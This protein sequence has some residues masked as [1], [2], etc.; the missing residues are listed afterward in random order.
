MKRFFLGGLI[1][2]VAA[3]GL[4]AQQAPPKQPKPKSQGELETLQAMFNAKTADER[5]KAVETLIT[6]YAD[7]DFKGIALYLAAVSYEQKNDYEKMLVYGE[8]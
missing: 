1:A 5:I 4:M 7:S 6:K 2:I 3:A 8:R